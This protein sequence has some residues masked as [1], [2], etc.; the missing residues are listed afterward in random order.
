MWKQKPE[1]ERAVSGKAREERELS[2]MSGAHCRELSE[3]LERL[4]VNRVD[5]KAIKNT[6]IVQL[7]LEYMRMPDVE[8]AT[9]VFEVHHPFELLGCMDIGW[10]KN[11]VPCHLADGR[12]P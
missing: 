12:K 8:L 1:R 11:L 7:Y 10:C 6:M 3:R 2:L 9:Q 4:Q 5:A